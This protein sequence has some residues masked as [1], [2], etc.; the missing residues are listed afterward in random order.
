MADGQTRVQVLDEV[1]EPG[2]WSLCFQ[3]C[4]YLYG[5]G[6]ME[7]GYR[8]IWR[9]P[10]GRLQPARGQARIPSVEVLYRLVDAARAAGWG[11][12]DGEQM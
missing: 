2:P 7:Y 11:D 9:K 12:R 4:R 3:W 6:G 10:D 5:E 8:F 1:S